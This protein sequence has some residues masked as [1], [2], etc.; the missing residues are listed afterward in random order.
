MSGY[1]NT[2]NTKEILLDNILAVMSTKA[3]G[4]DMAAYIVGGENRLLELIADGK[5]EC[6]KT[7]NRQNGKWFCNAAQVLSHC[8]NMRPTRNR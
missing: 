6:E 7:T 5:I 2:I 1:I 3:F 4:K 8:R